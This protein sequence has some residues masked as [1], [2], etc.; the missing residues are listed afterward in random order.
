M[1]GGFLDGMLHHDRRRF[2]WWRRCGFSDLFFNDHRPGFKDDTKL[3]VLIV[4]VLPNKRKE[5][6]DGDHDDDR[7]GLGLNDINHSM[8]PITIQH[9][10]QTSQVTR[11]GQEVNTDHE[12]IG[13]KKGK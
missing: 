2:C 13:T 12:K 3:H 11:V 5:P 6:E 9:T 8:I 1:T 10:L 7:Q 4:H